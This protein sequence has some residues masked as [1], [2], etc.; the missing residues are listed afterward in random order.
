[1]K[2]KSCALCLEKITD[3]N[4]SKE[5]IIPNSIGGRS[6]VRG[7]ICRSC[8]SQVGENWDAE[9]AVQFNWLSL[10][11]GIKRQSGRGQPPSQPIETVN[12]TQ[13][14]LH[15]DG[16]MTQ[17]HFVYNEVKNENQIQITIQARTIKEAKDAIKNIAKKYP[18]LDKDKTLHEAKVT[19]RPLDS[20]I[21][22][23]L[24]FGGP[25]FGR[26]LVKTAFA[27]SSKVN[28]SHEL[29]D[30]AVNYLKNLV[31]ESKAP[32]GF[33]Y[34]RDLV[35]NRPANKLFHC[36]AVLGNPQKRRLIAYVEYF[37]LAR[38]VINLSSDYSG[39][40][41]ESIYAIDP[42]TGLQIDINVD[43]D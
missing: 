16:N 8:N 4:N 15:A 33:F 14:L 35:R 30:K 23:D 11:V 2:T 26:S 5:H 22:M 36:V 41:I 37:G 13:L 42:T 7:F 6:Y 12:G 34:L 31:D 1:M 27:F 17:K 20:P 29:C 38:F 28:I 43:L 40:T 19:Q 9:L 32:Y 18:K 24:V 25:L 21:K 10:I 3:K 39:E